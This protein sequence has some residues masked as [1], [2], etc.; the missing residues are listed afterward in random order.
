MADELG[1]KY[2]VVD[3]EGR[4]LAFYASDFNPTIPADAIPIS[5]EVWDEWSQASQRKLWQ[6]GALV[7]APAPVPG[8][9]PV[10]ASIT[11]RQARLALLQAGLLDQVD[12]A[13]AAAG[14]AAQLEWEYATTIDRGSALVEGLAAS[15]PLTEAQLDAL[16]TA[17][18]VL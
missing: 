16:F 12:T 13:V 10:P 11:A 7:D 9:A 2:V 8:P 17:A 4:A 5:D 15:V 6:D 3:N 1:Q 18:A 14:R